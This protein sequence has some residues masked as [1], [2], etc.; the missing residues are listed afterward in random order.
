M[1][2][3]VAGDVQN[4]IQ[5]TEATQLL[6]AD[7]TRQ[8]RVLESVFPT[9]VQETTGKCSGPVDTEYSPVSQWK[10]PFATFLGG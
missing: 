8:S 2:M 4:V 7:Y 5:S 1:M 6:P 9:V 3:K 10:F